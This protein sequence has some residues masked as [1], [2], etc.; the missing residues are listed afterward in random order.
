MC[1]SLHIHAAGG[2]RTSADEPPGSVPR[3]PLLLII[4]PPSVGKSSTARQVSRL[5]EADHIGFACID[6]D[7]FGLDGLLDG[8][9]LLDLQQILRAR[10]AEGAE[11]LVVAW[12]IKS[13]A[14]L[15]AFRAA[16]PWADITV[17]RLRAAM[18]ELLHRIAVT[19]QSFHRLHMQSMA[20]GMAPRLE[21]LACE[22][23]LLATDDASPHAVAVRAMEQW[24]TSAAVGSGPRRPPLDESADAR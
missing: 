20:L 3:V 24:A 2:R 22:D 11:R 23:I 12:R 6:R 10:L 8:D 21:R 5:L 15:A 14:E 4:G 17:C 7:D 18:E 1:T 16:L 13:D 9:P 19:E